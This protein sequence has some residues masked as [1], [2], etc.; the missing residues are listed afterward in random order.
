MLN[1][2]NTIKT[3]IIIINY[4]SSIGGPYHTILS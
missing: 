4:A 3:T 2:E 1:S